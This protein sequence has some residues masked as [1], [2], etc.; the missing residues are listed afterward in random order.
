MSN[1][2]F[3]EVNRKLWN[4]KTK[5]HV[6]SE[7]Y[8]VAAFKAGKSS[9]NAI[10]LDL[11]GDVNGK[12]ILHLQ[13]HFGMDSLS[14]AR[15]GAKVVGLDLSDQAIEKARELNSELGLDVEFICCNIYALPQK[16]SMSFDF[17]FTS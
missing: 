5:I 2:D 16:L 4:D 12:T 14:L 3:F 9:L 6:D 8:D 13:C 7:F 11:L 1:T 17:V 15:L 10:E